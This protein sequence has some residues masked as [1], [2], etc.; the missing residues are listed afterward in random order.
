MSKHTLLIK[1]VK[2]YRKGLLSG[3]SRFLILIFV[4]LLFSGCSQ[5]P[6]DMAPTPTPIFDPK[7]S[8]NDLLNYAISFSYITN[9]MADKYKEGDVEYIKQNLPD[10]NKIALATD[11]LVVSS[12]Y[13]DAKSYLS[14]MMWSQISFY[15]AINQ[16]PS[17]EISTLIPVAQEGTAYYNLFVIEM[18]NLGHD[19]ITE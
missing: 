10:L 5:N 2:D 3:L 8:G 9:K 12:N 13:S 6:T 15:D 17:L 4:V 1:V 16:N 19:L 7:Q 14:K 18:E 11:Q